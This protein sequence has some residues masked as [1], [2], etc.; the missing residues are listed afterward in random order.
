MEKKGYMGIWMRIF[1]NKKWREN[2]EKQTGGLS[3]AAARTGKV[4]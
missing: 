3:G 2:Y 1:C 4:R